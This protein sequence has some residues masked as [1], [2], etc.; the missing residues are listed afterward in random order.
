M[1]R[2]IFA[3]EPSSLLVWLG[4]KSKRP[5]V[6]FCRQYTEPAKQS[7][8]FN[9]LERIA[10]M[11]NN[12][13]VIKCDRCDG[14]LA[15]GRDWSY[16]KACGRYRHTGSGETEQLACNLVMCQSVTS[17]PILLSPATAA[18]L[19]TKRQHAQEERQ[20]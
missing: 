9:Q 16:C 18:Y 12:R 17:Q 13:Q 11:A 8:Q 2:A 20:G 1:R 5:D 10:D 19:Q 15:Y 6:K 4:E 14:D 3:A 7:D